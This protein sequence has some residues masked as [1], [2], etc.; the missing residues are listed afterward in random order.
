MYK[1]QLNLF[2]LIKNSFFAKFNRLKNK[3]INFF[4]L[5]F[6]EIDNHIKGG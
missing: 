3:T 6:L 4:S 5:T 2:I 1:D